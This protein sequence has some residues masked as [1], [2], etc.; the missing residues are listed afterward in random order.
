MDGL[1]SV[2]VGT[3]FWASVSFLLV[4]F[5]LKRMAWGPILKSLQERQD[6]IAD[7]LRQA[8][9]AREEMSRLQA[10]NEDLLRQARDER[11]QILREAKVVGEKMRADAQQRAQ[12]ESDRMVSAARAEIE[13]QKLAA[14]TEL[15]N[16][17]ATLSIEIAE[18]LVREKLNDTDKQAA[19][20]HSL[21][22]EF[23]KN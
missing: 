19:L 8:D 2:S 1:L 23:S 14:I 9:K 15:K 22:K 11:D 12:A 13:N 5:L 4:L 10:G 18:K 17:V 7:A 6:G 21:I 16:Q 20:N 3:V